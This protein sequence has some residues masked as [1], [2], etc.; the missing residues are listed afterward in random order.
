MKMIYVFSSIDLTND[1]NQTWTDWSDWTL[2]D[3]SCEGGT[4]ERRRVCTKLKNGKPQCEGDK[5][6]KRVCNMQKCPG[7][8]LN[9]YC[10]FVTN[11]LF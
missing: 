11:I 7:S 3:K 5:I 2:C 10:D 8:L 1:S 9:Y 6:E 4:Q